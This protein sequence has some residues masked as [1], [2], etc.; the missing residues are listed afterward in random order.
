M[1]TRYLIIGNGVAGITAAQEIRAHDPAGQI[2]IIGDEG[3]PYYYRASLSEWIAEDSTTEQTYART[4]GFY[5]AMRIEN[6]TGRVDRID[7]ERKQVSLESGDQTPYDKLLIA[8]GA[9]PNAVPIAGLEDPMAYRTWDDARKIKEHV[10]PQTNVLILGGGVL[11][12]ELAGALVE[13]GTR[14][15]AIVQ[16]L[17]FL[18]PP[19]LDEHAGR[20][21]ERRIRADG[22]TL[23]LGD[24]VERVEGQVA[25][26]KSGKTRDFDLFVQSVGVRPRYPE[27]PGLET[28]RAVRIDEHGATNLPDIYAAGDCTETCVR[29]QGRW[30]PTRIWLDCARQGR[31]AGCSMAGVDASLTEYPFL[32]ASILY[33]IHYAYIGDPNAEGGVAHILENDR[34]YR[35]VRLVD[36]NLAGAMLMGD[37]R[38]MM[39]MYRAIGLPV[40]EYGDVI[41]RSDFPWNDLTGKD[42]EYLFF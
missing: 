34:A 10:D 42:W 24:T 4:T 14:N 3:K 36:G 32:N 25:H 41:A 40:A 22:L 35:K 1:G 37:R 13:I 26:L 12:L 16:L 8:T 6:V 39:P 2:T 21:L 33:D 15:I 17:D 27:V 31:V 9:S 19:L 20:W 38:G 28:G 5:E 30:Q 23:F 7:A 18:G 29:S 11:G